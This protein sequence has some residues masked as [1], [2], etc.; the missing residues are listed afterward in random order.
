MVLPARFFHDHNWKLRYKETWQLYTCRIYTK[1][2]KTP[3]T[4]SQLYTT[5][6]P[7]PPTFFFAKK[8]SAINNNLSNLLHQVACT[9]RCTRVRGTAALALPGSCTALDTPAR[10]AVVNVIAGRAWGDAREANPMPI[11]LD[12]PTGIWRIIFDIGVYIVYI[13][14]LLMAEIRLTTW[15]VYNPVNNGINYQP[16]LVSRSS[17]INSRGPGKKLK[18]HRIVEGRCSNI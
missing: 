5:C 4:I 7:P 18:H 8:I 6:F 12:N 10:R 17:A 11:Q 2:I 14:I 15:D 16:H 9:T 3:S 13:L 1:K